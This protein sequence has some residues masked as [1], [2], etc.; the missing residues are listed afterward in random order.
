VLVIQGQI[1]IAH[2]DVYDHKTNETAEYSKPLERLARVKANG[3]SKI[4]KLNYVDTSG[5]L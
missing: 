5:L 2:K 3:V 1:R 4:E